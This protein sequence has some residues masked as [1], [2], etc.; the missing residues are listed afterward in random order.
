MPKIYTNNEDMFVLPCILHLADS[1]FF[2][3]E[4]LHVYFTGNAGG[5]M[6]SYNQRKNNSDV[7][8]NKK[9]NIL[10]ICEFVKKSIGQN[11]IEKNYQTFDLY[12]KR[13]LF[14]FIFGQPLQ[15]C[16]SKKLEIIQQE[17]DFTSKK[18]IEQFVYKNLQNSK[19]DRLT[20]FVGLQIC[21][22]FYRRFLRRS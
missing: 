14:A 16:F 1:I 2:L 20:K 22:E 9:K 12:Q 10:H 7:L 8:I 11:V 15:V 5:V 3:E 13:I 6:N 19:L 18:A 21:Y 17:C 4:T